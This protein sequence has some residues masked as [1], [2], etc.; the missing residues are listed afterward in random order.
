MFLASVVNV[1]AVM[2]VDYVVFQSEL[3]VIIKILIRITLEVDEQRNVHLTCNATT[4]KVNAENTLN[5]TIAYYTNSFV[6][7]NRVKRNVNV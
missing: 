2:A 7:L 3:L 1:I 5:V 6:R 4:G